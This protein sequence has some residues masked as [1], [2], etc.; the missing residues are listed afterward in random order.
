MSKQRRLRSKKIYYVPCPSCEEGE[1]ELCIYDRGDFDEEVCSECGDSFYATL[2]GDLVELDE[3]KKTKKEALIFVKYQQL[4]LIVKD[5]VALEDLD[6][7]QKSYEVQM[8][9]EDF[10]REV[11]CVVDLSDKDVDP[12]GMFD[13]ITSVIIKGED[14][15]NFQKRDFDFAEVERLT[16]LQFD[17][18]C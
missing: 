18:L 5:V 14:L 16:G 8:C 2:Q 17:E 4:L 12:H 9:P 10:F 6:H 15:K 7:Q 11:V 3:I 1:I 13:Y